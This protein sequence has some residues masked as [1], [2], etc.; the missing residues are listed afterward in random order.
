M[1]ELTEP[2]METAEAIVR[3][4]LEEVLGHVEFVLVQARYTGDKWNDDYGDY[5][6][7]NAV[8]RGECAQLG[9]R[10]IQVPRFL[11][12]RLEEAGF[13]AYPIIYYIS[14]SDW[15]RCPE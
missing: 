15:D 2:Q 10:T 14:K 7:V 13:T 5:L 11:I 3:G 8:Y 9:K 12:P 6:K 1:Q 4:V